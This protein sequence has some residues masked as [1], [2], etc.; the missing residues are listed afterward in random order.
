MEAIEGSCVEIRCNIKNKVSDVDSAYW[1]W[2]KNA[3]WSDNDYHGTII[4]SNGTSQH[5]VS[6]DFAKRVSYIGSPSSEWKSPYSSKPLCS[7]LICNLKKIDSGNYSLRYVGSDKWFTR[8]EA[9]LT[10]DGK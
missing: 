6:P 9:I 2:M 5:P 4:Y 1:F 10:V 7:I 8:E 3:T